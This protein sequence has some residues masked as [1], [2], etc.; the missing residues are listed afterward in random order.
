MQRARERR[1]R[2]HYGDGTGAGRARTRGRGGFKTV[3]LPSFE[4]ITR[5]PSAVVIICDPSGRLRITTPPGRTWVCPRRGRFGPL[6]LGGAGTSGGCSSC[7]SVSAPAAGGSRFGVDFF[8]G[9]SFRWDFSGLFGVV[10]A[11]LA[12]A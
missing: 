3:R 5:I 10:G 6:K 11:A 8:L 7:P 1:R 2:I 4:T 9:S 12:F